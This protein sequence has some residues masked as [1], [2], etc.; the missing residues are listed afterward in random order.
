[1]LSVNSDS[2]WTG[3]RLVILT[4]LPLSLTSR[5]PAFKGTF[6]RIFKASAL[7]YLYFARLLHCAYSATPIIPSMSV[8]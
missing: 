3:V 1:M 5:G 7:L 6:S 4:V 8:I 2:F